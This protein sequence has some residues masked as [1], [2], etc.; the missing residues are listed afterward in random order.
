MLSA[1]VLALAV[2]PS[3]KVERLGGET[4]AKVAFELVSAS[5]TPKFPAFWMTAD[6]SFFMPGISGDKQ[7]MTD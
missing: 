6:I 1:A 5:R 7:L 2:R 4:S 3:H